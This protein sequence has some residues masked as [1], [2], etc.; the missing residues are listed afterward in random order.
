LGL[1][2][3]AAKIKE[4]NFFK[5]LSFETLYKLIFDILVI[6]CGIS[7]HLECVCNLIKLNYYLYNYLKC[8]FDDLFVNKIIVFDFYILIY[9]K[10]I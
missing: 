5:V 7:Y 6:W 9:M 4:L 2:I 8:K 10:V 3:N 1:D